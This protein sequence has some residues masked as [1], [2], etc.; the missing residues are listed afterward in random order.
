M[1]PLNSKLHPG[2]RGA[3]PLG[4][5]LMPPRGNAAN[6]PELLDWTLIP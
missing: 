1:S 5:V 2:P 6:R 3:Q 4:C